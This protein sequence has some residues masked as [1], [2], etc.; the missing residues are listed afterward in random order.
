[1]D[2]EHEAAGACDFIRS[3]DFAPSATAFDAAFEKK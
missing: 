1:M 2:R 3:I